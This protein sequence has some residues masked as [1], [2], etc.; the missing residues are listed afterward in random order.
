V[1]GMGGIETGADAA[2]FIAAGATAVA[3]GT[4]SFRDPL[5]GDRVREGLRERL[6]AAV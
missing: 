3:V 4:A 1:I 2:D 5:A 6:G